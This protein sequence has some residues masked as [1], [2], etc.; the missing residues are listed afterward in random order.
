[1]GQQDQTDSDRLNLI[2]RCLRDT[3]RTMSRISIKKTHFLVS[4][5]SGWWRDERIG[6]VH[7]TSEEDGCRDRKRVKWKTGQS[8]LPWQQQTQLDGI[9]GCRTGDVFT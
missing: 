6:E 8:G 9:M 4:V 7:V 1:M 2:D 5:K 3:K